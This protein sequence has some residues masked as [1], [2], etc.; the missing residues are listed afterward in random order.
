MIEIGT[1]QSNIRH[2]S[3]RAVVVTQFNTEKISLLGFF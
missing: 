1:S 3:Y 2:V